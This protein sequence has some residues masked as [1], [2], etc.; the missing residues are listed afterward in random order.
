M[1]DWPD[2]IGVVGFVLIFGA[3]VAIVIRLVSHKRWQWRV[4]L[5]LEAAGFALVVPAIISFGTVF[6]GCNTYAC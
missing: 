3:T 2:A 1:S 4:L 5:G 6:A